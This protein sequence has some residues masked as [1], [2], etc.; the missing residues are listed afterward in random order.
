[1]TPLRPDGSPLPTR[2]IVFMEFKSAGY[3][4]LQPGER[5]AARVWWGSWCGQQASDRAR[6]DWPGGSATAKVHGP[7]QPQCVPGQPDNL[8]SSWFDLIQ[9]TLPKTA[10]PP[11]P[12]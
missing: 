6:V 3:V 2:T 7:V 4:V 1:M 10:A 8:S 11:S 5:A 12:P 9:S